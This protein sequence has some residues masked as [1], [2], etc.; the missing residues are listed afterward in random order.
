MVVYLAPGQPDAVRA[1]AAR[2]GV[3]V[4]EF[5]RRAFAEAC[6]DS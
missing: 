3:S 4:S 2:L 1:A 5:A 6:A